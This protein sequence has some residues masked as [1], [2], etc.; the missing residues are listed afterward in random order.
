MSRNEPGWCC[1]VARPGNEKCMIWLIDMLDEETMKLKKQMNEALDEALDAVDKERS[2]FDGYDLERY[3]ECYELETKLRGIPKEIMIR[4]FEHLVSSKLKEQIQ[5]VTKA[6]NDNW[7]YFKEAI[8]QCL[9]QDDTF[10]QANDEDVV[11]A[12]YEKLGLIDA[13]HEVEVFD[14]E[15]LQLPNTQGEDEFCKEPIH[16]IQ[17]EKIYAVQK[18]TIRALQEEM[19]SRNQ[20][21]EVAKAQEKIMQSKSF[22]CI[23]STLKNNKT[24]VLTIPDLSNLDTPN[25]EGLNEQ[26]YVHEDLHAND[27]EGVFIE[28]TQSMEEAATTFTNPCMPMHESLLIGARMDAFNSIFW[29]E[30]KD[31]NFGSSYLEGLSGDVQLVNAITNCIRYDDS[32]KCE[33]DDIFALHAEFYDVEESGQDAS[34]AMEYTQL[35]DLLDDA[36]EAFLFSSTICRS[37]HSEVCELKPCRDEK[38]RELMQTLDEFLKDFRPFLCQDVRPRKVENTMEPTKVSNDM[39]PTEVRDAKESPTLLLLHED[40]VSGG[41]SVYSLLSFSMMENLE[42]LPYDQGGVVDPLQVYG[43]ALPFD[44]DGST[45]FISKGSYD[46]NNLCPDIY[47]S[48]DLGEMLWNFYAVLLYFSNLGSRRRL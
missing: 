16:A 10:L 13:L 8:V 29:Q 47:Q 42:L 14:G 40:L 24:M 37:Q 28:A 5:E 19:K 35:M 15:A 6:C 21:N 46:F 22:L 44:L 30:E 12:M 4:L 36:L 32:I 23:D 2:L 48:Y 20:N 1:D 9:E 18:E 27:L 33:I 41:E 3:L 34:S 39:E 31:T 45:Y 7:E 25:I 38:D 17:E 26:R 43:P 11:K